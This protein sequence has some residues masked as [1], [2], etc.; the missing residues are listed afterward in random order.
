MTRG[1]LWMHTAMMTDFELL[2]P[3]SSV[4]LG[5]I[6]AALLMAFAKGALMIAEVA[7]PPKEM[8]MPIR[9]LRNAGAF[10]VGLQ[11]N[12]PFSSLGLTSHFSTA[13]VCID[14]VERDM[15]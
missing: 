15:A 2:R 10:A 6:A 14:A 7:T 1:G 13:V 5:F 8:A 3:G 11:G 9:W 4:H 12:S